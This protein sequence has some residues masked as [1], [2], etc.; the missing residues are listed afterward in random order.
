MDLT[1]L[2]LANKDIKSVKESFEKGKASHAY[3]IE[4]EESFVRRALV[5]LSAIALCPKNGC[6]MCPACLSSLK[7]VNIDCVS[8][9]DLKDHDRIKVEDIND[10][11]A[12]SGV[13]PQTGENKVFLIDA[14]KQSY[15]INW[16]HK[17]LKVLEE[18]CMG[19]YIFIG[20]TNAGELLPTVRSRCFLVSLEKTPVKQ[21][22]DYFI[23]S[24]FP[25]SY[26]GFAAVLSEGNAHKAEEILVDKEYQK[27]CDDTFDMFI[28]MAS[29]S[30]ALFYVERFLKYESKRKGLF[31]LMQA[32][33][34]DCVKQ[35]FSLA[36]LSGFK[37][38]LQQIA[39]GYSPLAASVIAEEIDKVSSDVDKGANFAFALD[40]II[41]KI[42]EVKY[43]C[44]Q[45]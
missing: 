38:Q 27:M 29:S 24:G 19:V 44:R 33:L 22:A 2:V 4:G 31:T 21:I 25:P 37:A 41:M 15:A 7:G 17:L 23:S 10:L 39:K 3:I 30:Q 20:V 35:D 8:Y 12:L 6:M 18:P 32:I 13:R 36:L 42:L 14:T 43:K 16:Q 1:R 9:P 26:S 34:L 40:Y 28:N 5:V 45:S 11:T